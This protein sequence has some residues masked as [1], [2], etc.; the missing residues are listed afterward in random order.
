MKRAE[1]KAVFRRNRGEAA[2]LAAE[3]EIFQQNITDWMKGRG[4]SARVEAAIRARAVELLE[5]ERKSA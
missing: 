2:K 1:I 5:A 4:R 3:L